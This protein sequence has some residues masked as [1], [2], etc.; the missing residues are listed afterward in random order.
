MT[1][2]ALARP[3]S[4]PCSDDDERTAEVLAAI[5]P[6]FAAVVQWNIDDR[7]L[8]FPQDHPMLGWKECRVPNCGKPSSCTV[9]ICHGCYRRWDAD[10]R[11]DV[12]AFTVI[13]KP[14]GRGYGVVELCTVEG[15][16]R[17]W[18]S[19]RTA[20]CLAHDAQRRN[21]Q[22][23]LEEF[24]GH[25]DVAPHPSLGP[26]L[27]ASCTRD[28][29]GRGAYCTA[30]YVRWQN[31]RREDADADEHRWRRTASA[32]AED[33]HVSLRG[34]PIRVA[35]ELVYGLQQRCQENV[36]TKHNSVRP[37]IT[38]AL[39]QEARSLGDVLPDGLNQL[40]RG[41]R[42]NLVKHVDMLGL[43]PETERHKDCW[44][45]AVFGHRGTLRFT[46]ISQAWLREAAKRWAFETLPRRRG[47]QAVG[48]IQS[49]LAGL[50]QLSTSLHLQRADH[51][52]NATALR[53]TD[54]EAFCNRLAYLQDKEELS[55]RQRFGLCHSA[56][57]LLNRLRTIGLTEAG[58]LLHGLPAEF[59]L[60]YEDMPDEP[61]DTEAGR[62]LPVDVI[63]ELCA[64][65]DKVPGRRAVD[66][67]AIIELIIDTGRRPA[68]IG[69]LPWDCLTR[70]QDGKPVLI[71]D[72]FKGNRLG[73]RLPISDA[74][75]T[76]IV[77]QQQR[78][79]VRF[80][81]TPLRELKLFPSPLRNPEGRRAVSHT[82]ASGVHHDWV[83]SLP[84]IV[85]PTAMELDGKTVTKQLPF[86]KQ[87]IFLY[88]Y[89]HT[90][91]QRH[92]DAG[93]HA[94]V[95]RDLMD[96][97]ELSTTQQYYRVTEKRRREAVD[98]VTE[99]QFDRHGNR[100]WRQVKTLLD[101]EHVRRAVGEVAVPYGVCTEPTNVAAGGGDCPIRFRCVGCGHFRTDVSYLPD[102]EAY[103]A[104]L[105]RN[106]ERLLAAVDVDDWAKTEALPSDEEIHRVR[107]LIGRVKTDLDE[108]NDEEK[109][110]I[111]QA[112]TTVRRARNGV[113]GL[114]LPRIRQPLPDIRPE[115]TA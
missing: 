25:P 35:A 90:Y 85:V 17:P 16:Q 92:A 109:A 51:G 99:M 6:D 60:S 52:D 97:T 80:P 11:P 33:N 10:G 24:R 59:A 26:C 94:D 32:I 4:T 70:D 61:E 30:H 27:V 101:S 79:R 12:A 88:A 73:R 96:H 50:V 69:R 22:V 34:L 19:R 42:N 66:V 41:I 53:R 47:N 91:A 95:L 76:V 98:R 86:D 74:T 45:A 65:L 77:E 48:S 9:G 87:R 75:A 84:E 62:D 83:I 20:L 31:A 58:H 18:K 29:A 37:L 8:V 81:D 21:L 40:V 23:D 5:T 38:Q 111:Q 68:E 93:V 104:D 82:W 78:V 67:R 39:Q 112:V 56:R 89:R 15:C 54:I 107:T 7:V 55:A 49:E 28:R 64:H 108:L 114:G 36:K 13:P 43:T 2:L 44:N 115:R 113:V 63:R 106:R 46:G 3:A 1:S 100:I 105:L 110:Q 57:R 102:L 71:Y 14:P 103:L 72:N